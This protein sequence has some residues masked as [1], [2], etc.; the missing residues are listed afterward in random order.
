MG[1]ELS[2]SVGGSERLRGSAARQRRSLKSLRNWRR[3]PWLETLPTQTAGPLTDVCGR[4]ARARRPRP[5]PS[6]AEAAG[7]G[8]ARDEW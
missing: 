3:G 2:R 1:R 5:A 4:S 7:G 8:G 6:G